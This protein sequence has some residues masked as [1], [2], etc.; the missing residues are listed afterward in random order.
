MK[1]FAELKLKSV[2]PENIIGA[3]ELWVYNTKYRKVQVYKAP[4][5]LAVKGTTVIGFDIVESKSLTLRKPE[6]F[7]KGLTLTKR[8]LN[9]AIK[10]VKTKAS[11]PNGRINEECII[12]GAF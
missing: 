11:V 9:A 4:T 3:T 6:D 7:F 5:G 10:S 12:L 2:K 1:E 8:P